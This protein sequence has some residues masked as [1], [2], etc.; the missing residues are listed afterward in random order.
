[1]GKS[2]KRSVMIRVVCALVAIM[3]F[4]GVSTTNILRI[5]K[6]QKENNLALTTLDQVYK[7]E[8]AHYKWSAN[9]SNALYAG[10]EFTGSLDHTSCVL[11][12]WLYADLA[13][14]DSEIERLRNKIEPLHKALHASAGT[15]LELKAAGP[16]GV[17]QSQIYYQDTI[18][19]NLSQVVGVMEQ[20]VAR[21]EEISQEDGESVNDIITLMHSSTVACLI[22]A[23]VALISLVVYVMR[24]VIKPLLLITDRVKPLQEGNLALELKYQSKNEL[25]QMAKTLEDSVERISK[26][27]EDIDRVMSELAQ[28]NFDVSTSIP[29]IGDFKT[30]ESALGR[31][32]TSI[33]DAM[34]GITQAEQRV[35]GHA[36]QLSS[37]AQAL[38]QGAT[39]QASAVEELYATVDQ[40]SKGA[41]YNAKAAAD[42]Q[43][44]ARMTNE[45]VTVSSRQMEEMVAAMSDI[46]EASQQIS[47][48]IAT[49]ESIAF[50][51]NILALN[52]AVEAARAGAAG[53]GFAVV[54]NEVRSLA[55]KSDEAAK[56]TKG[57]I[58]NSVQATNRGSHIVGEVS[59]SLNQ[60]LELVVQSNSAI[61]VIADA[62]QKEAESLSQVSEGIGQVSAVVQTNSASSEESAAV[63]SELFEQ[64]HRL[65]EETSK[66]KLKR[67]R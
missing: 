53:K 25:G 50:Q 18:L 2:I 30:I 22:L 20:L 21:V 62:I 35:S 24:S 31:F 3:L 41:A 64:V 15:A 1:M 66:F 28:G 48:I 67:G 4:S 14:E 59:Q 19:N 57:L 27:V 55:S 63:S 44:S 49:I 43:E 9:L 37:G 52:A 17:Q 13:L 32:T 47:R 51:T 33:S 54:A 60:A 58:E 34:A 6:A 11:G 39:E 7:A 56:A 36:D 46:T 38:A 61:G 8:V 5:E 29:Y 12:K 10:S 16:G 40:L 45:Q 65:E 23:L 26:Y 42:A